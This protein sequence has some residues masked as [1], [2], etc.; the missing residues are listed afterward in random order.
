V[1]SQRGDRTLSSRASSQQDSS[2]RGWEAQL[3]SQRITRRACLIVFALADSAQRRAVQACRGRHGNAAVESP[4]D[5][6]VSFL[7]GFRL[8][9]GVADALLAVAL[10]LVFVFAY[11]WVFITMGL[12]AGNAQAAQGISMIFVP[13]TFVSSA[14]VPVSSLPSGLRAFA[15]SQ[16][17]T[18]MTDAVR[19]L[20][21]DARAE[22]FL[23]HPA[24]YYVFRSL[25]RSA[26]IILVFGAIGIARY[27]RG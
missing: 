19:S 2:G 16:P 24:S 27:R 1:L 9:A 4:R 10:M 18:Y 21:G 23:G 13:S 26:A 6:G 20:T 11:E 8:Q 7:I 12:Y 5:D 14:Y 25:I 15:N 17:V 3:A 22:E